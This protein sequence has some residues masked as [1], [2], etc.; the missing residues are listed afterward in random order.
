[1]SA[2]AAGVT[3]LLVDPVLRG[4]FARSA[5]GGLDDFDIDLMVRHQEEL[6]R[7]LSCRSTC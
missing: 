3:S 7:W 4:R 2:L 6:Y 1:V 5:P